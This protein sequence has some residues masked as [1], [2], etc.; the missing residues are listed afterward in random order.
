MAQMYENGD[1][2]GDG[3]YWHDG[4][5]LSHDHLN[6]VLVRKMGESPFKCMSA[7]AR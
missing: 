3:I 1:P 4:K 6:L 2:D 7:R 5:G